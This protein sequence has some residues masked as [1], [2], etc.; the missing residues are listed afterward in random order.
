MAG[1]LTKRTKGIALIPVLLTPAF[2]LC[3]WGTA[4]WAGL[5]DA[6]HVLLGLG[7]GA[8]GISQ[9]LQPVIAKV[10]GKTTEAIDD[11]ADREH[12]PRVRAW[13][14]FAILVTMLADIVLLVKFDE[15]EGVF[16]CVLMVL[17]A[18]L[19][20]Y[21]G[22]RMRRRKASRWIL[23]SLA[24]LAGSIAINFAFMK[25]DRS[26]WMQVA[27]LDRVIELQEQG[28][29]ND[30]T[31]LKHAYFNSIKLD[32]LT[33]DVSR[34]YDILGAM[35][36]DVQQVT[37]RSVESASQSDAEADG[38]FMAPSESNR[39]KIDR[40]QGTVATVT[41]VALSA[42]VGNP[43]AFSAIEDAKNDDFRAL[44]E[45]IDKEIRK[46]WDSGQ[47]DLFLTL[48]SQAVRMAEG[49][50]DWE[51]AA[52]YWLWILR[53]R[54]KSPEVLV[55]LASSLQ[56][57]AVTAPNRDLLMNEASR[58]LDYAIRVLD[59]QGLG[60]T[61]DAA[62]AKNNLGALLISWH[63]DTKAS[64]AL[65]LFEQARA[66]QV[67][68]QPGDS[69][70][71][72]DILRNTGIAESMLARRAVRRGRAGPESEERF[73]RAIELCQESLEMRRRLSDKDDVIGIIDNLNDLAD[74]LFFAERSGQAKPYLEEASMLCDELY[75][76]P[77]WRVVRVNH[78]LARVALVRSNSN[79]AYEHAN[80]AYSAAEACL[81]EGHPLREKAKIVYFRSIE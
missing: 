68:H 49:R 47:L 54:Q 27:R 57:A 19:F 48:S 14:V 32:R 39:A 44:Y 12:D 81:P 73:E 37:T 40:N 42:A 23:L 50:K 79:R 76:H 30:Q 62:L 1:F 70:L 6:G 9:V 29:R 33:H 22:W 65:D 36:D 60:G 63:R 8:F 31:L 41:T 71:L 45:Q 43:D 11:A 25:E 55:A 72:A 16:L 10:F 58:Y 78:D 74:V 18:S 53:Q 24:G 21:L 77:H 26:Q 2:G 7:F 75:S 3:G 61:S 51:R 5:T 17:G 28:L 64:E 20:G 46:A 13:V 35:S 67:T 4:Y 38:E 52:K 66:L 59:E 69:K 15:A 34:L 80:K 56:R